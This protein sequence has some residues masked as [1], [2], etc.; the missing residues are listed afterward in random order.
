MWGSALPGERITA[1]MSPQ[2]VCDRGF[3]FGE[4]RRG[5]RSGLIAS[6][7]NTDQ[8]RYLG[9]LTGSNPAVAASEHPRNAAS[10]TA[11]AVRLGDERPI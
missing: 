5:S 2:R 11:T 8:T 9:T 10:N 6:A 3:R 7:S 1:A 4:R